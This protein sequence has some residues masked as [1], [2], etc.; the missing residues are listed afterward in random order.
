MPLGAE[1]AGLMGAA[2]GAVSNYFGDGSLGNCQFGASAI[3]QTSDTVAIDTVLTTGSEA[4]G[5]GSSSYGARVPNSSACYETT[6]LSKSGSYDGDMWVGNFNDLTIDASVTLT[7]D[8]P[9]RGILIYVDGDCIINGSLSMT[10]RGGYSDPTASG[11][12]D[13][14]AVGASGLQI[15]LFTASGSDS[16]TN[17]G[18]GFD[19]AGDAVIAALANQDDIS[20]DGTIF[21]ISKLGTVGIAANG[22]PD[23][24]TTGGATVQTAAGGSGGA[25]SG[26]GYSYGGD[27]GCFCGGTAGG[28]GLGSTGGSG[29]DFG[30]RGGAGAGSS[31]NSS[32]CGNPAGS[33]TYVGESGCAGLIWLI[34]SGDLTIA[35][36]GSVQA[37][38]AKGHG[39]WS[40]STGAGAG[41]GGAVQV[42]YAGTLSNSGDI[43]ANA[44]PHSGST[45]GTGPTGN[46]G[47]E[48]GVNTAQIS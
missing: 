16:F 27:A 35:S 20:S 41:G 33:A 12:S 8:Q 15:G 25:V 11:G 26:A 17:D 4:G 3:T 22:R 38:G 2:G 1:K 29:V 44:G 31:G 34:V 39:D 6:V 10:S 9:T 45:G 7:T 37:N 18:S 42:L 30:G 48:G 28:S 13:A 23:N 14:S 46:R 19:G 24:G 21:T 36:G 40:I 43:E 32:G 5:P 47:G